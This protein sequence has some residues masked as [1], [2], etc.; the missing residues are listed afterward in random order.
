MCAKGCAW[1]SIATARRA[2]VRRRN[3]QEHTMKTHCLKILLLASLCL[4]QLTAQTA[5]AEDIDLFAGTTTSAAPN[6]LLVLDNAANFSA[7][8]S[9]ASAGTCTI[10]GAT[11][12]MVGT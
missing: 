4:V 1:N 6:L 3:H 10:G 7:S 5:R 11:N 2:C 8:A 12:T 9:P